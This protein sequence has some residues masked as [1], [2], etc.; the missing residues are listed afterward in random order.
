MTTVVLSAPL[1][2]VPLPSGNRGIYEVQ[3]QHLP[4]E[5][6]PDS[7]LW[8]SQ[9]GRQLFHSHGARWY[10]PGGWEEVTDLA[11]LALIERVPEL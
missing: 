3:P 4:R 5:S 8:P 11:T 1:W 2:N 7:I 9:Y 10:K 6:I